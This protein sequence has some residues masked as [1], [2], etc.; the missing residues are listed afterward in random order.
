MSVRNLPEPTGKCPFQVGDVVVCIEPAM[1]LIM[2]AAYRVHRINQG[3]HGHQ[4]DVLGP[5]HPSDP[6]LS[7]LD[8]SGWFWSRFM[9]AEHYWEPGTSDLYD[10]TPEIAEIRAAKNKEREGV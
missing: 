8:G 9:L 1:K 4:I 3:V 7:E 6:V 5:L 2:S 10:E